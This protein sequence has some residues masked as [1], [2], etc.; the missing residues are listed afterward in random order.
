M[1]VCQYLLL[2]TGVHR[3]SIGFNNGEIE[4]FLSLAANMEV[5]LVT[6]LIDEDYLVDNFVEISLDDKNKFFKRLYQMLTKDEIF[7]YMPPKWQLA[8]LERN[9]SMKYA[10]LTNIDEVKYIISILPKLRSLD[11][12]FLRTVSIGL[13]NSTINMTFNCDGTQIIA[14][15]VFRDFV[16]NNII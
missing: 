15:Q 14:H 3:L 8:F 13:F 12:Y 1:E 6:D 4:T 16:A 5:H 9:Q 10:Q 2:E 7:Y 11:G